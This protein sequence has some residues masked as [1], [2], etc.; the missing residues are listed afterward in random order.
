MD[1]RNRVVELQQVGLRLPRELILVIRR[2]QNDRRL[3]SISDAF[4]ELLESHPRIDA[5]IE[6]IYAEGSKQTD[7]EGQDQ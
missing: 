3:T 2:Y 6:S 7:P 5:V 4:R 1:G